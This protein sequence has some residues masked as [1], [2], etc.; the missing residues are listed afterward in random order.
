MKGITVETMLYAIITVIAIFI[1]LLL[2]KY[3]IPAIGNFIDGAIKGLKLSFC[4][5]FNC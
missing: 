4:S 2:A 1:F 3:A 5:Y